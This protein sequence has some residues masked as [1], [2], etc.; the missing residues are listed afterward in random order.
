MVH[1][2]SI[3]HPFSPKNSLSCKIL[4]RVEIVPIVLFWGYILYRL[5]HFENEE[6]LIFPLF[7]FCL[8]SH[9]VHDDSLESYLSNKKKFRTTAAFY[10]TL[11]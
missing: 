6:I 5:S 11:E 2:L 7:Y 8:V 10:Q 9:F 4:Q 1:R 3:H